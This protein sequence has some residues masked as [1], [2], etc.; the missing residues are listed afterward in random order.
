MADIGMG[1]LIEHDE[2]VMD[3]VHVAVITMTACGKLHPGDDVG[4]DDTGDRSYVTRNTRKSIGIVDPFLKKPVQ[5]GQ[6]FWLFLYPNSTTPMRHSW[7]HPDFEVA[8][9]PQM[10]NREAAEKYMREVADHADM[11]YDALMKELKRV[12][13]RGGYITLGFDTPDELTTPRAD[14]WRHWSIITGE[15]INDPDGYVLGCSC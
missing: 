9:A 4:F 5:D 1:K 15:V 14:M 7:K 8:T 10:P 2:M 3:A 11:S 12:N 13:D 6:R